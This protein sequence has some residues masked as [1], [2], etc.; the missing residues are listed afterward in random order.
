MKATVF[1]E[2]TVPSVYHETRS[3]AKLLGWKETTRE[4]WSK[5]QRFRLVTSALVIA[6]LEAT[7]EPKRRAMLQLMEDVEVLSDDSE[8][9]G[10]AESYIQAKLLPRDALGD[11]AHLAYASFHEIQYLATWNCRHLANAWKYPMFEHFHRKSGLYL[12]RIVTPLEL[13]EVNP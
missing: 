10:L 3:D 12:P 8:I 4:F 7:P 6:E 1:I 9:T 2:T 5:R 11:A 13:V